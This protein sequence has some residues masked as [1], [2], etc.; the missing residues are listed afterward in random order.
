MEGLVETCRHIIVANATQRCGVALLSSVTSRLTAKEAQLLDLYDKREEHAGNEGSIT[1]SI[2]E[3]LIQTHSTLKAVHAGSGSTKQDRDLLPEIIRRDGLA[4][5]SLALDADMAAAYARQAELR[6]EVLTQTHEN[7]E[8][9]DKIVTVVQGKKKRE[10]Q[11]LSAEAKA[12]M[13][14]VEESIR[15]TLDKREIVRNIVQGLL[16]ESGLNW[17]D[18]EGLMDLMLRSG[19]RD[20]TDS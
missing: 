17:V 13:E 5:A 1:T 12:E 9:V 2:I 8:L 4:S 10:R 6:R 20:S 19:E 11:N 16:L 14:S 18:N 7:K 15:T 3:S